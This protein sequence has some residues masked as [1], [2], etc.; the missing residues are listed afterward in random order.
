MEKFFYCISIILYTSCLNKNSDE[1]YLIGKE[2]EIEYFYPSNEYIYDDII[3]DSLTLNHSY[4]MDSIRIGNKIP[5]E[6]VIYF[7]VEG[8]NAEEKTNKI[9]IARELS[10]KLLATGKYEILN[11]PQVITQG[12]IK[13][14]RKDEKKIKIIV[15]KSYP[16]KIISH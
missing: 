14:K 9:F 15:S 8:K 4:Y 16:A 7:S 1:I 6:K 5:K 3:I 13:F 2:I 11:M 10:K 12:V